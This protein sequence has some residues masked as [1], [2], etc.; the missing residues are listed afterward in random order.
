MSRLQSLIDA[1]PP[2]EVTRQTCRRSLANFAARAWPVIEPGTPLVWGWALDVMC[3]HLEAVSRGEIKR[4]LINVPPGLMKSNLVNVLWPA[5]EWG[6]LGRPEL[7]YIGTAHRGDLAVRD[8]M[9]CRRLVQSDWYQRLWPLKITSDQNSKTKFENVATGFREAIPFGSLTGSRGDRI[10]IDDP[11]SVDDAN[12][13]QKLDAA[14]VTF[15]EAIP[16]RINDKKSAI[17]VIKQRLAV[18]DISDAA[19]ELGYQHLCLPMRC[20]PGRSAWVVGNGDRRASGELLFPER[21]SEADVVELERSL[22]SYAA[23]GQLQQ[24]PAPR[25]GALI[26]SRWWQY[27]DVPPEIDMVIQSWD[28]AFKSGHSADPS[29]CQ[30]WGRSKTGFYLLD[31]HVARLE[32][33]ELRRVALSLAERWNPSAVL[34]EDKSSGQSLVQDLRS[35]R[36]PIVPVRADTDKISRLV[37]CTGAIESGRVWLPNSA[38]WLAGFLAETANFPASPH[39]DQID[40]LSQALNYFAQQDAGSGLIDYYR[41]LAEKRTKGFMEVNSA[42]A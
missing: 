23:A 21:F 14:V 27:F 33:P 9:R 37:A 35:T 13:R 39:D 28:T 2:G 31:C 38:P 36:L 41:A 10:L 7:R 34:V 17:V 30:T 4:L 29:C 15:R 18:G 20:E 24:R 3:E 25:E 42:V 5:W 6:P 8:S 40:A 26:K 1:L 19:L 32:Y 11:H 22:G 12:S 16:S